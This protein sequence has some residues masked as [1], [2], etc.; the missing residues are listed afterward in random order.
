MK[1]ENLKWFAVL[2]LLLRCSCLIKVML[3][4]QKSRVVI[5]TTHVHS[6]RSEIQNDVN[7]V[8][9]GYVRREHFVTS[10]KLICLSEQ[11]CIQELWKTYLTTKKYYRFTFIWWVLHIHVPPFPWARHC[12]PSYSN[13]QNP[14][15]PLMWF[16]LESTSTE[17]QGNATF[18]TQKIPTEIQTTE[19]IELVLRCMAWRRES[20][21]AVF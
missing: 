17:H 4:G 21:S 20:E 9:L 3:V 14:H 10:Y 11:N 8:M 6:C 7:D 2:D 5:V 13:L 12:P 18:P 19:D 16:P 1:I 15:L